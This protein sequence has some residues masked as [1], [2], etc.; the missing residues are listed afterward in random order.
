MHWLPAPRSMPTNLSALSGPSGQVLQ[1]G[2]GL[3]ELRVIEKTVAVHVAARL[4]LAAVAM[5]RDAIDGVAFV[6]Y[7]GTSRDPRRAA[8]LLAEL[9]WTDTL[10][11]NAILPE[12]TRG[13]L[14]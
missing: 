2:L 12:R 8:D 14:A 13:A 5:G 6:I 11:G 1:R 3:E 10:P 9:G 4:L 7:G